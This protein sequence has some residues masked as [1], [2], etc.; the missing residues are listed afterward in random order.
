MMKNITLIGMSG[1]GKSTIG[2]LL[3][4]ALGYEFVD[5]DLMIQKKEDMLLQDIIDEKGI[6]SFLNIEGQVIESVNVKKSII[7]TGGSVVYRENAMKHLKDIS[8]VIYLKV[9]FEEIERRLDNITTRGIVM[10]KP[11]TLKDVY[12]ERIALYEKYADFQ[13]NCDEMG[14]EEIV[15][16]LT[17]KYK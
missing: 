10:E 2:V 17:N 16:F 5:T 6:V 7:S 12:E 13:L 14:I 15:S 8:E 9:S 11:M 1:A 4:K 3:A